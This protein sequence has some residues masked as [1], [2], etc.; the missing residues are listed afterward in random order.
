MARS[1]C[2]AACFE[3]GSGCCGDSADFGGGRF[4]FLA[5]GADLRRAAATHRPDHLGV[6]MARVIRCDQCKQDVSGQWFRIAFNDTNQKPDFS[7]T[8]SPKGADLCSW[9]CVG[10]YAQAQRDRI[11]EGDPESFHFVGERGPELKRFSGGEQ[12]KKAPEKPDSE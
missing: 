11:A 3:H 7:Y 12:A 2:G 4:H 10:V 8:L 6:S 5:G 1:T 9:P